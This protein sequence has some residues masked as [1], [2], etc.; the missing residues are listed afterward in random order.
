MKIRTLTIFKDVI[1][2]KNMCW[3]NALKAVQS[4]TLFYLLNNTKYTWVVLKYDGS[5]S[6]HDSLFIKYYHILN[7]WPSGSTKMHKH[8][9]GISRFLRRFSVRIYNSILNWFVSMIAQNQDLIIYFPNNITYKTFGLR[10]ARKTCRNQKS[11][12]LKSYNDW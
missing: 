7:I 9:D 12:L 10:G 11:V 8:V 4:E 3:K 6:C 1:N 5:F 2:I